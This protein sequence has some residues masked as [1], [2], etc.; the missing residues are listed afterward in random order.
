MVE[1]GFEAT[2]RMSV[3]DGVAVA[4]DLIERLVTVLDKYVEINK[5]P[6]R[7]GTGDPLFPTEI[8]TVHAI[9]HHPGIRM[10]DLASVME[11]SRAAISQTVTKLV[12]KGLVE[13]FNDGANRKEILLRLS[14]TGRVAFQEHR[15]LHERIDAPF[16]RHI[17]GLSQKEIRVVSRLVSELSRVFDRVSEERKGVFP[18]GARR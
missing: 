5:L 12:R 9:G 7:F 17:R 6:R 3:N 14:V 16:V 4:R 8:H 2:H 13:R 15:K 18:K 10:T 11:I 1:R